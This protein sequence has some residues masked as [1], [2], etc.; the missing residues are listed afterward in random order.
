MS[1]T[2]QGVYGQGTDVVGFFVT[3]GECRENGDVLFRK[4]YI[5]AHSVDYY[6]KY[7]DGKVRGMW[8]LEGESPEHFELTLE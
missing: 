6:G 4:Q 1:I 7:E 3:R 8:V 5:G 2:Q